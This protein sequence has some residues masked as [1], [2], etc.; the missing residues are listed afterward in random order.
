HMVAGTTRDYYVAAAADRVYL[1]PAGGLR[2]V[3][4]SSTV[5]YF[6]GIFDKLGVLAQFEKI[7]EYKSAPEAFTRTGSSD[8]A[9]A[10]RNWLLDGTYGRVVAA[11]A[12]DRG[13]TDADVR[14]VFDEGPYTAEEAKKVKGLVDAVGPPQ[15]IDRLVSKELGGGVG[16]RAENENERPV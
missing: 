8:E 13:M 4:M 2:L 15:A 11:L 9:R 14:K 10:M 12:R 5:L 7:E 6:K 1:D 16:L 3:G